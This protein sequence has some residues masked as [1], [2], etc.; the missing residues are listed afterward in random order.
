MKGWR[1]WYSDGEHHVRYSS[2]LLDFADLPDDEIQ[3][4]CVYLDDEVRP[5]LPYRRIIQGCDWIY[6]TR[7]G[8]IQGIRSTSWNG[9]EPRPDVPE[10]EAKRG[11]AVPDPVFAYLMQLADEA[12]TWP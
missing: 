10:H 8:T 4:V 9:W 2:A 7:L 5:G 12:R 6:R 11:T 1:A 3:I